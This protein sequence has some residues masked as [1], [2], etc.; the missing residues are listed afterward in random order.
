MNVDELVYITHTLDVDECSTMNGGCQDI[1]NN[2]EGSYFCTCAI[3]Y[4]LTQNNRG[5]EGN[6]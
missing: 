6:P 2:T 1:C 4:Q 3:G 5:C